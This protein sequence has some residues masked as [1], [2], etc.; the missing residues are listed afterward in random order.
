MPNINVSQNSY[1][2]S[3]CTIKSLTL[4]LRD[5]YFS[6]LNCWIAFFLQIRNVFALALLNH[7]SALSAKLT[8]NPSSIYFSSEFR[9]PFLSWLSGIIII[10]TIVSLTF[11][12]RNV[13]EVCPSFRLSLPGQGAW[14]HTAR[15][16]DK[17]NKQLKKWEKLISAISNKWCC[18]NRLLLIYLMRCFF[19]ASV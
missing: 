7:Q 5:S 4:K 10:I 3:L 12:L 15:K 17:L 14:L 13:R 18:R 11:T 6:F 2:L 1:L 8:L 19:S 16:M 9:N